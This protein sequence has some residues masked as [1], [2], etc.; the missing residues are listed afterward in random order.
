[1][2]APRCAECDRPRTIV[3][4][5]LCGVCLGEL[6]GDESLG[7]VIDRAAALQSMHTL[8]IETT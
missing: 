1:M 2:P 4:I 3:L 6:L 5:G 7:A 8:D